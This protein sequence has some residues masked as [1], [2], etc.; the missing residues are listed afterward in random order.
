MA[1]PAQQQ[2]VILQLTQA[3]F[4]VNAAPGAIHLEALI[5]PVEAGQTVADLAQSLMGSTFFGKNYAADLTPEAF[6]DAFIHDLGR[7]ATMESKALAIDYI[8]GKMAA[9][10]MQ[11]EIIAGVTGI[12][13]ARSGVGNG[14]IS[15]QHGECG[16]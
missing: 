16:R 3:M 9:G 11:G 12:L 1:L 8:A 2:T 10:A 4:N 7:Y 15:V 6:A 13:S 14:R 5:S